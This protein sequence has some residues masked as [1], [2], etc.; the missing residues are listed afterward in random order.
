MSS[1]YI[2]ELRNKIGNELIILPSVAA[3][4]LNAENSL[5]LQEKED[6]VWSLP[7]GMIEPGESPKEVYYSRGKRRNW[8]SSN[9]S[10]DS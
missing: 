8:S 5:L 4:I 1:D 9:T 6:E 2:K 7:A 10:K 3:V